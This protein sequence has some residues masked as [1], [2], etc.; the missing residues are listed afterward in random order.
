MLQVVGLDR[1]LTLD[2]HANQIQG[3]FNCPV[4]NLFASSI[5][6][7]HMKERLTD[8]TVIVSPDVGGVARAVY[9]AKGLG[10][11]TAIIHKSRYSPNS[12]DEMVLL[13]SVKDCKAIIVDDMIDTAGTLVKAAHLLKESGAASIEAY[14]THGIFSGDSIQDRIENSDFNKIY[15]TDSIK[16]SPH[17]MESGKI[18]V[19]SCAPLLAEAILNIHEE[20]SVSCLF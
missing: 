2:L 4:D 7:K 5:F 1:V 15:V 12:V 13:G 17:L 14:A 3:Y 8:K 9:Y 6:C 20:T 18:E 10:V 11:E 16:Q 19:I